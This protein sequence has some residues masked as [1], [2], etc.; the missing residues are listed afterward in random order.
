MLTLAI[1]TATYLNSISIFSEDEILAEKFWIA[2]QNQAETL[3]PTIKT[4][5][6]NITGGSI[7]GDTKKLPREKSTT[8]WQ[9]LTQIFAVN[10]PGPFTSLR[11]GV[12][13]AN[14]LAYGL[15]IPIYAVSTF[16]YYKKRL[17]QRSNVKLFVSAGKKYAYFES[18][19]ETIP[20]ESIKKSEVIY[21]N[22]LPEQIEQLTEQNPTL[23]I[24]PEEELLGFGESFKDEDFSQWESHKQVEPLYIQPPKI[25]MSKKNI[26]KEDDMLS[27]LAAARDTDDAKFIAHKDAWK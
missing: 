6:R 20:V 13:T 27:K 24:I 23:T 17:P 15:K 4:L 14:T 22:I 5:L 8:P 11:V 1:N 10:G 2:E 16:D 3:I 7:A 18:E 26:Q 12:I 21:G 19:E 25:T 9:S